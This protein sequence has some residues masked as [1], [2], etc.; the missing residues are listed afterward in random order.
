MNI[1]KDNLYKQ[2]FIEKYAQCQ[3][4]IPAAKIDEFKAYVEEGC[5]KEWVVALDTK[6]YGCYG[7]NKIFECDWTMSRDCLLKLVEL[8]EEPFYYNTLGYIYYYGRCNN[9]VPEYDKAFQ[10][11]AVGA[12]H[13]IFESMYKIADMFIAGKGCLKN[14]AAGAKI[15]LSMFNENMDIFC[16]NGFDS[17]FS[18]VA[19]RVGGLFEKGIGVEQ[20]FEDAFAFY[21]EAKMAIDK[22]IKEYDFYGDK[23]V[24]KNI[25][26]ALERVR[27]K[28][29]EDFFKDKITLDNPAPMGL[30]LSKSAG[31]DLTLVSG[32]EGYKLRA[33]GLASEDECGQVV[34]N[35]PEIDYCKLINE[36]ELTLEP[37][38]EILTKVSDMPYNAFVTEI[39]YD[40]GNDVWKFACGESVMLA[41]KTDGFVFYKL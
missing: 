29:P 36:V 32:L 2:D 6:A 11:F 33:K 35:I 24:Q 27:E 38:T 39:I 8:T 23:K 13:G 40:E 21:N 15:I 31:L 28:L 22:R 16:E 9:G 19:L 14:P 37:K 5:K 1:E 10:Y 25:E 7:G 20:S 34:F 12:A 3:D 41:L 18:D 17:K 26:E 4:S 30:L